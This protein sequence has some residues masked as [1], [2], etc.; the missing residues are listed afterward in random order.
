MQMA[1]TEP[2]LCDS[3]GVTRRG[4][5]GQEGE[6][7]FRALKL[8]EIFTICELFAL[9]IVKMPAARFRRMN[10]LFPPF[11]FQEQQ[12]NDHFRESF[13][14]SGQDFSQSSFSEVSGG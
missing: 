13:Q 5:G 12:Q 14:G 11:F 9:N 4:G 3:Y 2:C 1:A 10:G 6:S 7:L 8:P